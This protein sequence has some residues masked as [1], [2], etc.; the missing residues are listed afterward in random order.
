MRFLTNPERGGK[1]PEMGRGSAKDKF[2]G[3]WEFSFLT[4]LYTDCSG[5]SYLL[6]PLK[7]PSFFIPTSYLVNKVSKEGHRE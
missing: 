7:K 6:W 3:F 1:E 4:V 5:I 2:L